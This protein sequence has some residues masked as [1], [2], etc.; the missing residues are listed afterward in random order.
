MK[1]TFHGFEIRE[2]IGSGGMSTVYR[3]VHATLGYPVAIKVLHPALA[4]D[5]NFIARFEREARSASSLRSNN[6]ATVIDFGTEN[7]IYFIVMEFVD[8][9]DLSQLIAKYQGSPAVQRGLPAEIALIL[10]DEIAYGLQ[11]AH[12]QSIIHRDVKPSNILLNTKGEVKIADFG[13]ARDTSK[14]SPLGR[15][16]LTMPGMVVG[17]PSYM[18]PEQ[19]VGKENIDQGTD[20][21]SLGVVAYQLLTGRKPFDGATPAE[22]QENIINQP[23]PPLEATECPL[24]TQEIDQL[25]AKMLAK[26]PARRFQGMEQVRRGI[27]A[28]IDS[29][30]LA[31]NVGRYR[32]EYLKRFVADPVVFSEEMRQQNIADRLKRGYHYKEMGLSN[33]GDAVQ[34]FSVVLALDP[35]N[36]KAVAALSELQRKAEESGVAFPAVGGGRAVVVEDADVTRVI[37]PETG[38]A[39][40]AVPADKTRIVSGVQPVGR[41]QPTPTRRPPAAAPVAAKT[42]AAPLWRRPPAIIGAGVLLVAVVAMIALFGRGGDDGEVARRTDPQPTPGEATPDSPL[43]P[44][45]AETLAAVAP[46]PTAPPVEVA[47]ETPAVTFGQLNLTSEPNGARVAMRRPQQGSFQPQGATP[48]QGEVESGRWELRFEH[49]DYQGR[50]YIVEVDAGQVRQLRATL[51]PT[52]RGPGWLRLAVAPFADIYVDG[53][54][55]KAGANV[56]Y[57]EVPSGRR[58]LVEYRRDDI[59]GYHRIE[60][61]QAAPGETLQVRPHR[62]DVASLAVRATPWAHLV[63]NGRQL[64][65]ETPMAF[66]HIAA[67][68]HRVAV[69]R[70][71]FRVVGA[72]LRTDDGRQPLPRLADLDGQPVFRLDLSRGQAARLEFE[73]SPE[74]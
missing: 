46:E 33:L 67:G 48:W 44:V 55:R 28:A 31:G 34:E 6:I 18:S 70:S 37:K 20:I 7:D 40:L 32:R 26:D 59:F 74:S 36:H 72:W 42:A 63:L 35:Q 19:A 17:T 57:V 14:V 71:G 25:L 68:Q 10:V 13:L 4:G 47:P 49:T 56:A 54:L 62:F 65:G 52:P 3:G 5:E 16:D 69:V 45:A 1:Q 60:G 30:D 41:Q 73:L 23:V 61:V 29:I 2:K 8:G 24:R 51:Q 50:S 53:D 22:V 15:K 43:Q 21:F 39:A 58:H 27:Q 38:A 9:P 64:E 12:H 11:E 66:E